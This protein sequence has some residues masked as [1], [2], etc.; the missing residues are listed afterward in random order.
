MNVSDLRDVLAWVI[1]A[2]EALQDG[3]S[4][5]CEQILDDLATGLWSLIEQSTEGRWRSR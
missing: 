5:F 1:R 2:S 4:L 3:E